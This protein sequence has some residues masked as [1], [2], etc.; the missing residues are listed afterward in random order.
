MFMLPL[1]ILS[2]LVQNLPSLAFLGFTAGMPVGN[3]VR[4]IGA[5]HGSL[6]CR[7]ASDPRMRECTGQLPYP[8]MERPLEV[9]ISSI[10]DSAA[11]I[12]FSGAPREEVSSSWVGMFTRTFG[13]PNRARQEAGSQETWQW[14]RRGRM[15]RLV[16]RHPGRGQETS[17]T[18]THGPLLDGLGPPQRKTPD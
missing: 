2:G 7:A 16:Q 11:V 10:N 4:L 5:A 9:L 3:A 14:I 17:I 8:G 6:T 15:L 12:V 1:G 18:L 13:E